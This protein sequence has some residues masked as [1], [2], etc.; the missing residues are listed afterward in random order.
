MRTY[1]KVAVAVGLAALIAGGA[2]VY[3]T[4]TSR[5]IHIGEMRIDPQAAINPTREYHLVLWEHDLPLPW[6]DASHDEYLQAAI[7]EFQS[8][9]PNVRIDVER[10]EWRE[11]DARL[12]ESLDRGDP[13][14]VYG[15]P[16]GARKAD[17]PLQIPVG[18][19]MSEE[20]RADMMRQALRAVSHEGDVW[21]WPRW[22]QP[23]VWMAREDLSDALAESRT[24]WGFERLSET[25]TAVKQ[26]T[27]AWGLA[28]NP[29]EPS[30]F[31]DVMI[32]ST[33]RNLIDTDGSRGWSVDTM[34]AALAFFRSLIDAKLMD[35]N[36]DLMARTRL[37]RFWNKQ[38][39]IIAPL[40]PW[41]LRHILT[42][43]GVLDLEGSVPESAEHKAAAIPPPVVSEVQSF[44]PSTVGGYAVYMQKVYQGDDHTKAAMLL[45]EHLSRRLGPWEA[46]QLFAVPAHPASWE[47]WR[48]DSGLPDKE[49]DLLISWAERA[50]APPVLDTHALQQSRAIEEIIGSELPKVWQNVSSREVAESIA[51]KVDGLRAQAPNPTELPNR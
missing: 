3:F 15:M 36:A 14:D 24:A 47:A 5:L 12:R 48:E 51:R 13:P 6:D 40:T 26:E 7:E 19:Y 42:R 29:Y 34:T 33:G 50:V 16:L 20:S 38:A 11:G 49:L 2:Y 22:I 31:A 17:S 30:L 45:A 41:M 44:H 28:V 8:V 32:G 37:L 27:G 10:L 21:A 18:P 1:L 46:A 23:R 43:A 4:T 35:T 39:A 25:L 9:Y